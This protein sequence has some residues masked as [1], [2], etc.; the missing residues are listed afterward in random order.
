MALSGSNL[1]MPDDCI[2]WVLYLRPHLAKQF[3]EDE[4][5]IL[6]GKLEYQDIPMPDSD[7]AFKN[8]P[9]SREALDAY[10]FQY[11]CKSDRI[12]D[13]NRRFKT[14]Q[15]SGFAKLS[16]AMHP[17]MADTLLRDVPYSAGD[18]KGMWEYLNKMLDVLNNPNPKIKSRDMHAILDWC[19]LHANIQDG[20]IKLFWAKMFSALKATGC[21]IDKNGKG[22]DSIRCYNYV[23][24]A[25]ERGSARWK[26]QLADY[27]I[28]HRDPR[29]D[30]LLK[31]LESEDSYTS[32][33][34]LTPSAG[35]KRARDE[36][37]DVAME[38][39]GR[40]LALS[41][42]NANTANPKKG[43][44]QKRR[45]NKRLKKLAATAQS[46]NVA[47]GS[48]PRANVAPSRPSTAYKQPQQRTTTAPQS[49]SAVPQQRGGPSYDPDK[50]TKCWNC[51]SPFHRTREC[52]VGYCGYCQS[53]DGH[54]S[55]N[56]PS[57]L[58]D[59]NARLNAKASSGS[60][61]R[62]PGIK[63]G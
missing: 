37:Q 23:M 19:E 58:A 33:S 31:Y 32:P 9:K 48:S 18:F 39:A 25:I 63:Q 28:A 41:A 20:S 6:D 44:W 24:R 59:K 7:P 53:T 60:S 35:Q 55:S 16:D 47:G 26:K 22:D 45:E 11:S 30:T 17:S 1:Q 4:T 51:N 40:L 62:A 36:S 56:C 8:L 43:K 52:S 15:A 27:L 54:L 57:R 10:K 46:T 2:N 38:G 49:P 13:R 29:L 12:K 3:N 5:E 21:K 61:P 14:A 42:T 50:A 34:Q